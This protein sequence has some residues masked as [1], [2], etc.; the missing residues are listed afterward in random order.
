VDITVTAVNK[1][2]VAEVASVHVAAAA[3]AAAVT[4]TVAAE[5]AAVTATV[6]A[7]AAAVTATVAAEA[8][9]VAVMDGGGKDAATWQQL[10]LCACA[11][12][13]FCHTAHRH[14]SNTCPD[15]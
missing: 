9:A 11:V 5:A 8:A 2:I 3:A 14:G 12:L 4:A 15:H 13:T 7:E 1:V 10:V 6:A